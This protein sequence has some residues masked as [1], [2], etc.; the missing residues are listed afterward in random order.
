M[1][2]ILNKICIEGTFL[3]LI[4]S[5][6]EKPMLASYLIV[7]E[8]VAPHTRNKK[9]MAGCSHRSYSTTVLEV[10][11]TAIMQGRKKEKYPDWKEDR[12]TISILR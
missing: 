12:K 2:K 3:N 6:Y 1:I 5:L 10:P 9:Q 7:K 4:K 8:Y 11:A